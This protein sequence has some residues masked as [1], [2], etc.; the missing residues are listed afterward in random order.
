MTATETSPAESS[1]IM[2][3]RTWIFHEGQIERIRAKD[4]EACAQFVME[5]RKTIN[6]MVFK[7]LRERPDMR[8]HFTDTR[9]RI[10]LDS[11]YNQ[12]ILD[13]PYLAYDNGA[14]LYTTMY[15]DSIGKAY[16]GYEYIMTDAARNG[17]KH[18][19]LFYQFRK[20]PETLLPSF[21]DD[22]TLENDKGEESDRHPLDNLCVV[23][24]VEEEHNTRGGR[25]NVLDVDELIELCSDF[26]N[27]KDRII[28]RYVLQGIDSEDAREE[29]GMTSVQYSH[30]Q[31]RALVKLRENAADIVARLLERGS[32][33]A[34]LYLGVFPD[35][36]SEEEKEARR[37][38][39]RAQERSYRVQETPEARER[40]LAAMRERVRAMR[41]RKKAEQASAWGA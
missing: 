12:L 29:L 31:Q 40:R 39:K 5:N 13:L 10:E 33:H 17:N 27:E 8:S 9:G 14:Y 4:G 11:F 16:I 18:S 28:L 36:Y 7:F 34:N 23:E 25:N 2:Q 22:W 6:N 19:A 32:R 1:D 15:R 24:S 3:D 37:Q 41:A 38:R 35:G 21:Y 30:A 20:A 26:L